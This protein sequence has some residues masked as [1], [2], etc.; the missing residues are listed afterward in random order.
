MRVQ[1][2]LRRMAGD[3]DEMIVL[4]DDLDA[5]PRQLVLQPADRR[6]RCRE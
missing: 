6:A 5:E 3:V 1:L 2:V 4:G